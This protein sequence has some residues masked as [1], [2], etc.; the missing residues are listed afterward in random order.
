MFGASSLAIQN[1]LWGYNPS[2][3]MI[4]MFGVFFVPS[5]K[6]FVLAVLGSFMSCFLS[7][8]L[9]TVLSPLGI[10]QLTFAFSFT[11]LIF[12]LVQF[13]LANVSAVP[14]AQVTAPES[15]YRKTRIIRQVLHK[16]KKGSD[17][18]KFV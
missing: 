15:H 8:A 13:S 3:L 11:A 12:V 10:P 2:L 17:S 16:L 18:S 5:P 14:L 1:G 9:Y 6:S 4:A 7:G